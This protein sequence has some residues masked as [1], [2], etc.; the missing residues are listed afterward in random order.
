MNLKLNKKTLALFV[1]GNM[2]LTNIPHA[3]A[4]M[5]VQGDTI[6]ATTKVN[7]RLNND[8]EADRISSIGKDEIAIR[9]L[10]CD[11]GWDLISYNDK[12]GF[13]KSEYFFDRSDENIYCDLTFTE[14]RKI[15][16]TTTNVNMRINPF[17]EAARVGFIKANECVEV[18]A[19]ASNGWY[20]VNSGGKLGFV[21]GDYLTDAYSD[22]VENKEERKL[23]HALSEVNIRKGPSTKTDRLDILYQNETMDYIRTYNSE[24]YV[25]DYYGEEAYISSKYVTLKDKDYV[26][27]DFIKVVEVK[28][29]TVLLSSAFENAETIGF[30]DQYETGEVLSDEGGFYLIRTPDQEGYIRKEDVKCL[31]GLIVDIDKSEQKLYIYQDNS[32]LLTSNVVTGNDDTPTLVGDFKVER[33]RENYILTGPGYSC[34]VS[35]WIQYNGNY[36]IHDY[37]MGGKY[38]GTIFHKNGSHGCVRMNIIPAREV[39]R[40]VKNGTP[41]IV[42]K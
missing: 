29:N 30:L 20:L 31:T 13:V 17:I 41:V 1:A 27:V 8:I 35:Y 2:M 6:Q 14:V 10:S 12:L 36:G 21:C 33:M 40:L 7:I 22:I 32:V 39:Y 16:K 42:H 34:P 5:K 26:P 25:V 38:G 37:D 23:V 9:I 4:E 28:K 24:W 18:L 11:N 15:L 19:M 3:S